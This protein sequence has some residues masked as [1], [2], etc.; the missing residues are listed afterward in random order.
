M[1]IIEGPGFLSIHPTSAT[2]RLIGVP[3]CPDL[4]DIDDLGEADNWRGHLVRGF[5]RL[6]GRPK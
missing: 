3:I 1:T 6:L 4:L 5:F 2:T